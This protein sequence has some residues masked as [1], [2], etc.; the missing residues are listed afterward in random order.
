M[1]IPKTTPEK[2]YIEF[3]FNEKGKLTLSVTLDWWGGK[4]S[5]FRSSD[6]DEGNT[7]LPKDLD[8]YIKAFKLRKIRDVE[9]EIKGLQLK[10]ERL[11][12]K[13]Q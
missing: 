13:F 8:S 10:L 9:K 2:P 12:T 11:K 6:G 5:G 4:G 7:C 3:R 1:K